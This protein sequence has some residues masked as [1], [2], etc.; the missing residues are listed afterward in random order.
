LNQHFS[1]R[2]SPR[3]TAG[4]ATRLGCGVRGLG[5][6]PRRVAG[7]KSRRWNYSGVIVAA[8]RNNA[9]G[10]VSSSRPTSPTKRERTA[11]DG[12][13]TGPVV[14]AQAER[15]EQVVD[16]VV[17]FGDGE[18]GPEPEVRNGPTPQLGDARR[19]LDPERTAHLVQVELRRTLVAR[20]DDGK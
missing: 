6:G 14:G 13:E 16:G 2:R 8:A 7:C 20:A 11:S 12:G 1:H 15:H 4:R 19:D 9:Q 5:S 10:G 18:R 3:L 17:E